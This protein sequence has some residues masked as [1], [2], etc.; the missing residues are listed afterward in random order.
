[1]SRE[2]RARL[3]RALAQLDRRCREVFVMSA[4][5]GFEHAEIAERLGIS[6]EAV[7]RHLADALSRLGEQIEPTERSWWQI[8]R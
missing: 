5:D 1:M 3:K 7:E 2:D 8:W 6:V 4:A